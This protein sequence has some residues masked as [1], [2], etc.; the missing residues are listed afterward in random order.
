MCF[1]CAQRGPCGGFTDGNAAYKMS[2]FENETG[3]KLV[4]G[5]MN[6][7]PKKKIVREPKASFL[8]LIVYVLVQRNREN[9]EKIILKWGCLV[10]STI[11]IS[12]INGGASKAPHQSDS[13]IKY[14][15]NNDS[16]LTIISVTRLV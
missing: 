9:K 10:V 4:R 14:E 2:K 8:V 12:L 15:E 1:P 11:G 6:G 13:N 5:G 7:M 16:I 3:S